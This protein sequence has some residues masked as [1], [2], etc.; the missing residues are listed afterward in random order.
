MKPCKLVFFSFT[1]LHQVYLCLLTITEN[2]ICFWMG[3]LMVACTVLSEGKAEHL[4]YDVLLF[5]TCIIVPPILVQQVL[6]LGVNI[7]WRRHLSITVWIVFYLLKIDLY[8]DTLDQLVLLC[9]LDSFCVSVSWWCHM[10]DISQQYVLF[11]IDIQTRHNCI[12]LFKCRC[13]C[14]MQIRVIFWLN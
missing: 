13:S 10:T 8:L 11:G 9:F 12:V 14:W 6:D 4:I 3:G 2:Y 1:I 5:I 7:S